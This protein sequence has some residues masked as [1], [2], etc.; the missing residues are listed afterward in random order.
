MYDVDVEKNKMGIRVNYSY[1]NNP[2]YDYVVYMERLDFEKEKEKDLQKGKGFIISSPKATLKKDIKNPNGIFSTKFGQRLGDQNPFMDRYSCQCGNLKSAVNNGIL[3]EKCN[4][5]CKFV[6]DDFAIFGWIEVDKEYGIINPDMYKQLDI[7]FG[8]SKYIKD[9]KSKRGS[10]LLNMID[11]D[12][13]MDQSGH[14]VGPKIKNN[15]PY[16][17]IG[18]IEFKEKFDEIFEYYYSKNKKKE[19]YDDIMADRDKLFINSIPVYTT[20]L[21]PMDIAQETMYYE[22]TN[23]YF[24]MMVKQAQM[25]N[26]NKRKI[27]RSIRQKNLQLFKLQQKYMVLYDEIVEILNG[28]KGELRNLVSGRFNYSARAVI[29]QNPNLRIDQVELPYAELVITEQQR[30]IN[31]LH[32]TLNISYQQAYDKWFNAIG[33]IDP[34][35]VNILEDLIKSSGEGIPV[36]IN[37]NPT[38]S[39]G[40]ILQM[41]C[42]GINFNY[43]MSMPL[44]VLPLLAADF[45]GDTLNI[46]HIINQNF[47]ERCY[48]VFNPRNNMYISRSNGLLNTDVVPNKDTL[49]NANTLNYLTLNKYTKE[50]LDHINRIKEKS[51]VS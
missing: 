18:M 5:I 39:F 50:E 27:D 15:E 26:K 33:T 36:I 43:T 22:K 19:L 32:R 49:V 44:Q 17:G 16:Y 10:V 11:F 3:C 45:D 25:I 9:K 23:G 21:R 46:L 38:I 41:F 42:V 6:D 35:V 37:R 1:P 2:D 30:I 40:S 20:L 8:R 13:E 47:F 4:T 12:Q 34:T 7:F 24:N 48:E 14:I 51:K 31:I 28:K 29:K